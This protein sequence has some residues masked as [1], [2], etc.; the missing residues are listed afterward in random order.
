MKPVTIT[1]QD[2]D[3][4]HALHL[5]CGFV[6]GQECVSNERPIEALDKEMR[7][8]FNELVNELRR[9][10]GSEVVDSMI[11]DVTRAVRSMHGVPEPEPTKQVTKLNT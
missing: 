1:F 4:I 11:A 7:R 6:V 2:V 8:N 10:I 3:P 5:L 9:S